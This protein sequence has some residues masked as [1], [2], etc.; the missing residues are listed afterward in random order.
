MMKMLTLTLTKINHFVKWCDE[1]Y[2][3]LNVKKTK[4]MIVDYSR[5]PTNFISVTI[6]EGNVEIVQEYIYILVI[7]LITN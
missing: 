4:E 3:N 7:S 6:K 2:I 5:S 1:N